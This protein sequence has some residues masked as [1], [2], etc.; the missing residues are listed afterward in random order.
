MSKHLQCCAALLVS[1]LLLAAA[2]DSD[3]AADD[4]VKASHEVQAIA[5]SNNKFALKMYGELR[6]EEGNIF[7]SPSSISTALAMAYAGA[8]GNTETELAKTLN[9]TLPADE[10]HTAYASL[11]ETLNSPK[12]ESYELRMANRLWGQTGYGFRPEYLATTRKSYGAELAQVDFINAAEASRREINSWVEEQ[13]SD[14]IKD[15]IP[16]GAVDS[17]TRLVLT[18]AIYFKGKWEH[19]FD[20][21]LTSDAP[22]TVSADKRVEV[23]LMYQKERYKYSQTADLQLLE[24]PYQGDDVSM[25]ILL[26]KK[27]DGLAAL[28]DQLSLENLQKWSARMRKQQVRTYIP[29][30]KLEEQFVLN[31]TL[32]ELGMASAFA[33]GKADFSGMNGRKDLYITAAIHKA[34]VDVNEEGTE[35]AAA[36][37]I[38][39]GVTSAPLDP[40]IFRADHPFIFMIRDN[41]TDAI[42]FIG[43]VTN[44]GG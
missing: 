39:V 12:K 7:F 35:A 21:K 27:V 15:L 9:F 33:P 40:I 44:P 19:E 43:R 24:M 3:V 13:T 25:V 28:E 14:K 18:N 37:G 23:P 32:K 6:E 30:F 22:F 5:Q 34:F 17:L 38:V 10:V 8:G 31:S 11:I 2:R 1:T 4:S 26:P 20:K 36:T 42:L 41:R 16:Q 29:R